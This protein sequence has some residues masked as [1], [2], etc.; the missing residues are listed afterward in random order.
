MLENTI[1]HLPDKEFCF[2]PAMLS[3]DGG[4]VAWAGV[5]GV[6]TEPAAVA[7]HR[8]TGRF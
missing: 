4:R 2:L 3:R 8:G 6:S 5:G 1:L 7:P